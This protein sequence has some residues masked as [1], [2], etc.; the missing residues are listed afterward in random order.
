MHRGSDDDESLYWT[1]YTSDEGWYDDRKFPSQSSITTPSLVEFNKRLYCFYQ[2][3]TTSYLY[4]CRLTEDG[5]S[6]ENN[7]HVT[8]GGVELNSVN[9]CGIAVFN[10]Q[11]HLVYECGDG[12]KLK[13]LWTKEFS[14]WH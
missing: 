12:R 7:T 5:N 10:E 2:G 11:L 3:A 13:R 14:I 6:W 9:G 8:L 1:A 4:Y